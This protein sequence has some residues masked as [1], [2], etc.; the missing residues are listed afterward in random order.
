MNVVFLLIALV[1]A[2]V[3]HE[4]A[5]ALVGYWLGDDTARREGRLTLNP[6]AHI[7]PLTTLLLPLILIL[8][9]SPVVFGAAKPVPFNPWALR[10]G[11]WGAALVAL[12]GPAT[13]LLLAVIFG[14]YLRWVPVG[15]SGY[16][17]LGDIVAV[18][19]AFGIFNLIPFPPLDGSRLLYA[20][21]PPALRQLMDAIER[22]G[23]IVVLV[24]LFLAY[25]FISPFIASI[26]DW[27]INLLVPSAG[28]P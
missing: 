7:D 24:I 27:I 16:Q 9:H 12:A 17:L 23:I 3:L 14:L 20:I 18:N 11:R 19:T 10:W 25:P 15:V 4:F 26:T 8:G 21:A 13:N 2:L 28:L 5:H 6:A 22:A 1:L